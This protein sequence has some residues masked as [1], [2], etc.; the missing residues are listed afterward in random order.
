MHRLSIPLVAALAACGTK[1]TDATDDTD[2][3]DTGGADSGDDTGSDTGRDDTGSD[4]GGGDSGGGDSGDTDDTDP[5]VPRTVTVAGLTWTVHT[6]ATPSGPQYTSVVDVD[7][8]DQLD[9]AV[10]R[11]LSVPTPNPLNSL[12]GGVTV[13]AFDGDLS[14]WLPA[15]D[16]VLAG[17]RVLYPGITLWSDL[18]GD[19][20][21]D[22]LVPSGGNACETTIGPISTPPCGALR[23]WE[24]TATGWTRHDLRTGEPLYAQQVALADL[25]DDG[26][27]DLVA[28]VERDPLIGG[29]PSSQTYWLKGTTGADRFETTPRV[30]ADLGGPFPELVD[31]DGDGDLDVLVGQNVPDGAVRWIEQLRA[32]GEP[33]DTADT[34]IPAGADA[35]DWVVHTIDDDLGPIRQAR[36]VPDL[37]GPGED[38]VVV[39]NHTNTTTTPPDPWASQVVLYEPPADPTDP[40]PD[41]VV[42]SGTIAPAG[43]VGVATQPAP[44]IFAVGDVDD[45]DDLD[46]LV[47]GF[48]DPRVLW[49]EQGA[50]GAFTQHD[51]LT[52]FGQSGGIQVVDLDADGDHELVVTSFANDE[53]LVLERDAP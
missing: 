18:D 16:V 34:A 25:D 7:G 14:T 12:N 5:P 10:S 2:P 44:G 27:V 33:A 23:W 11:L 22:A 52:A 8:D 21:L 1:T 15:D 4:T 40:W 39:T 50:A 3:P 29:T 53:V 9:I 24:Q 31:L 35:G 28:S 20:D 19:N 26:L 46:L 42:I 43:P 30:I 49:L 45:D 48:G 51:L 17:D 6:V 32:P 38:R 41:P 37:L 13:H 36:F 47:A